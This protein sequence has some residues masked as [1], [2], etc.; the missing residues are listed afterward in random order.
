[1]MG[2]LNDDACQKDNC[3]WIQTGLLMDD[4]TK[5]AKLMNGESKDV[6]QPTFK[7]TRS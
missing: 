4:E 7:T 2:Q 1:M 6:I 5:P 3:C